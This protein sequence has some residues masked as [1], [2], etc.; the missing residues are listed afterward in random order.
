MQSILRDYLIPSKTIFN[1]VHRDEPSKQNNPLDVHHQTSQ[2]AFSFQVIITTAA[3][4]TFN[5]SAPQ[6]FE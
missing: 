3:N 4:V 5:I 6:S 1:P 2:C